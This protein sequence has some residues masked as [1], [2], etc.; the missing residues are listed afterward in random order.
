MSSGDGSGSSAVAARRELGETDAMS[1]APRVLGALRHRDFALWWAGMGVS[2]VGDGFYQVALVWQVYELSDTP[3]ALSIVSAAAL[4]PNVLLVLLA[5]V[6]TDHVDRRKVLVVAD[7]LRG[8]AVGLMGVLAVSGALQLWHVVALSVVYGVGEALFGPAFA[9]LV[10][11]LVPP[12]QLAEANAVTH[13]TWHLGVNLLGP[14]LGGAL[15][16]H[17][18]AG[19]VLLLDAASFGVSIAAVLAMEAHPLVARDTGQHGLRAALVDVVT[20]VRYVRGHTWLWGTLAASAVSLLCFMGPLRVL[21]PY[22]VKN[23]LA[24][25]AGDLGLVYAAGGLGAIGISL[26]F[27][28]RGLPRRS[29]LTM[30]VAWSMAI[31]GVAAFGVV[32]ALWQA[33]LLSLLIQGLAAGGQLVWATLLGL[34]VP[35]ALLGRVS[36]L[37]L[38]L[39]FGLVPAS[40][41]ATGPVADTLGVTP[42]LLLAGVVG[43]TV[44][45]AFLFLPGMR[46]VETEPRT[47]ESLSRWS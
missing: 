45:L 34:H 16:A 2:V 14:A 1:R 38:L 23:R 36:S 22:V 32:G 35:R 7:T 8:V 18:G 20:G 39:S 42:T 9:A 27:S 5:G 19:T 44:F 17:A 28:Q 30:F 4:V 37:D 43:G 15:I 10:P 47:A 26:L 25:G 24:G 33:A 6:V 11:D 3:T 40:F 41:V 12:P 29:V 21:V 31:Y 13:L 46:S